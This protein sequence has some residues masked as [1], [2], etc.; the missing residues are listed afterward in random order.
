MV[1]SCHVQAGAPLDS[2]AAHG[3]VDAQFPAYVREA[4]YVV[5]ILGKGDVRLMR[6]RLL[7]VA[8]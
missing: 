2:L 4:N 3:V 5:E 7:N 1:K 8:V 6:D